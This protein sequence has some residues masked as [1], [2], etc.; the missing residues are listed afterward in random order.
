M[1]LTKEYLDAV[2][3]PQVNRF[4]NGETVLGNISSHTWVEAFYVGL[5]LE[6]EH[7]CEIVDSGTWIFNNSEIKKL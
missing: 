6:G 5:S 1:I 4:V 7:C 3:D 2:S